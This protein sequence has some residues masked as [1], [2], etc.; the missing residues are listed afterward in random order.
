VRASAFV[1]VEVMV[2]MFAQRT[3]ILGPSELGTVFFVFLLVRCFFPLFGL[4]AY[5]DVGPLFRPVVL[6]GCLF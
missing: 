1:A 2:L 4:V 3:E 6:F 5:F